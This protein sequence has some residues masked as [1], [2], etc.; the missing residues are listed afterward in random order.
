MLSHKAYSLCHKLISVSIA[1]SSITIAAISDYAR[2]PTSRL[3]PANRA[4]VADWLKQ[5]KLF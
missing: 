2:T 3:R 5:L 4:L 1:E